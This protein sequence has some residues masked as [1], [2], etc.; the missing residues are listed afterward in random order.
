MT[1]HCIDSIANEDSIPYQFLI[2]VKEDNIKIC[3]S[4]ME[5]EYEIFITE[6]K[7]LNFL[8]FS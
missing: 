2:L 3:I 8:S 4:K 6:L 7:I 1:K 5:G